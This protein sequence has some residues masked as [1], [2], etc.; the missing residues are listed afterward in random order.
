MKTKT[1]YSKALT[2]NMAVLLGTALAVLV[3]TPNTQAA[4]YQWFQ[5]P[6][7]CPARPQFPQYG[8]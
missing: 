4:D 7:G 3:I 5:E 8:L 6:G 2:P 1:T